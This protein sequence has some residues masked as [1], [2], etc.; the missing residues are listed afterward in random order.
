MTVDR[1]PNL[2]KP[3]TARAYLDMGAEKFQRQVA[4][5][6]TRRQVGDRFYYRRADLDRFSAADLDDG[7][8]AGNGRSPQDLLKAV[9]DDLAASPRRSSRRS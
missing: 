5:H 7:G 8:A 2:M 9:A 3:S 6:L 4:P 1:W